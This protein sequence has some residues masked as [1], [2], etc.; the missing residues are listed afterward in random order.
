MVCLHEIVHYL[1]KLVA[2][3]NIEYALVGGAEFVAH[4]LTGK[5][6]MQTAFD[7]MNP[8]LEKCDMV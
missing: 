7:Q 4:H 2:K 5:S 1:Q 3:T 6:T 8:A